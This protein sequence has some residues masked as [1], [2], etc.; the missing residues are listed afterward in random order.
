MSTPANTMTSPTPVEISEPC[1]G[2]TLSDVLINSYQ[3]VG[4]ESETLPLD[5]VSLSFARIQISHTP[6]S[7]DGSAGTPITA[8][9]D[10]T[11][12]RKL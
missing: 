3:T 12:N 2:L 8:G 4:N 10:K 5:Q 6:Q 7:Q 11:L 9:W 1:R